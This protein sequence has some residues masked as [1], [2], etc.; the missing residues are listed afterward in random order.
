MKKK[1]M[2]NIIVRSIATILIGV[3]LVMQRESIMPIIVQCI[4]VA[5]VLP[6]VFALL[7]N[8]FFSKEKAQG[9]NRSVI[10]L[11]SMG[12]IIFGLWLIIMPSFF[13]EILMLLLGSLLA[14]FGIYQIAA[15][16]AARKFS[17]A[18]IYMYI[19]PMLLVI[20]GCAVLFKP[21][22][23]ASLPFL[24]VGIG[25]IIGGL[26]DLIN[27]IYIHFF[28]SKKEAEQLAAKEALEL[29]GE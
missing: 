6:G 22:D 27:S 21:F 8:L 17:K 10:I 1:I 2:L 7:S 3:L 20:V 24:L 9:K 5:F 29:M 15:L 25:A 12:S 13:V 4:G 19:M 14:L 23:A 18:P 11:T 26:S 16:L 28:R